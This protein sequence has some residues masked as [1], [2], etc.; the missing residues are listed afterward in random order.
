MEF[1]LRAAFNGV[2]RWQLVGNYR[3][4]LILRPGPARKP[5]QLAENRRARPRNGQ[6]TR[7]DEQKALPI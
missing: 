1:R 3:A 5:G 6:W 4:L 7:R 2:N